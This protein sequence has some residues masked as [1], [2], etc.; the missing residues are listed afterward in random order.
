MSGTEDEDSVSQDGSDDG[1]MPMHVWI[2]LLTSGLGL[3]E[4]EPEPPTGLE[5]VRRL[6]RERTAMYLE[7]G[8]GREMRWRSRQRK[9]PP[10]PTE[11]YLLSIMD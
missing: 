9:R 11:E 1:L 10:S 6:H 2:A 7:D 8:A 4:P 5:E 3:P